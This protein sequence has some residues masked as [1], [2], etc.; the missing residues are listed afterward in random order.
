MP[1]H[2]SS[3]SGPLLGRVEAFTGGSI[4]V[5]NLMALLAPPCEPRE[6][7]FGIQVDETKHGDPGDI[8]TGGYLL[9]DAGDVLIDEGQP[10][11]RLDL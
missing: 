1:Q 8:V 3:G 2:G 6:N 5:T 7:A 4:N 11:L 9:K 10:V